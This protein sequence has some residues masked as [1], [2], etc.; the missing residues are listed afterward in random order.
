MPIRILQFVFLLL[1]ITGTVFTFLVWYLTWRPDAVE[2]DKHTCHPQAEVLKTGD[3]IKLMTWNVQYLA[4]KNYVFWYD[5]LDG[6]GKD[7]RPSTEDIKLTLNEVVKL[8]ISE[9]PDIILLQEVDVGSSRTDSMDQMSVLINKLGEYWKCSAGAFYWKAD[10]VPHPKIMGSVGM[11]LVTLSRFKISS[12]KRYQLP[13]MPGSWVEQQFNIK[14]AVLETVIETDKGSLSVMNTHLDAF[15]QGNDT[16]SKQ[17]SFLKALF[18]ER[19]E[20]KIPWL[21]G[22]DFNLLAPGVS[23]SALG[24][25]QRKYFNPETELKALTGQYSCIPR[26]SLINS[27]DRKKWMTHFPN[28]P[29]VK[30][31]DRTIDYIFYSGVSVF[32]EKVIQANTEKIS[33]HFPVVITF[34]VP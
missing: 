17:V 32:K 18:D 24:E 29:E 28:D 15:A 12:S 8:I 6:S 25:N 9:K 14:R 22:G 2:S 23:Y 26:I 11:K 21:C 31:P 3:K 5:L 30:S 19:T 10:F 13:L 4:G 1:L 27:S 33:D 34:S 20:K 16:M 7:K